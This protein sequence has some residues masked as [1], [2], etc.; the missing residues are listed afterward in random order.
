LPDKPRYN[1][2]DLIPPSRYAALLSSQCESRTGVLHHD[3]QWTLTIDFGNIQPKSYAWADEPF[4]IGSSEKES[5]ELE[6]VIYADNL[7]NPQKVK[8]TIEFQIENRIA[9]TIDELS[10]KE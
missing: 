10:S 6:A 3:S 5:L 9:L 8:L 4:Y 1:L 7:P 2:I